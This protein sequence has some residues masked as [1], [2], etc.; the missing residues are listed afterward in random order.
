[1]SSSTLDFGIGLF[2][3][4]GKAFKKEEIIF[5]EYEPGN[6]FFFL[7]EGRI[8]VTKISADKEKTLD[9]LSPGEIFGEMAILEDAPRS[10]TMIALDDVK[11]LE[12]NK[13]NF[14]G[15]MQSKPELAIKLLRAFAK[16][17]YDQKR[18][19]MIL[20]LTEPDIKIMD[21]F[22]ML[23]ENR[24]LDIY[25]SMDIKFDITTED[26]ANWCGMD[27]SKCN[28]ILSHFQKQN[29]IVLS[30]NSITVTNINDFYRMVNSKRKSFKK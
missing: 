22:L 28:Q 14:N 24:G 19:L 20:T 23:A 6:S 27:K 11:V 4:F 17:I 13:A 3:K 9:I 18:R 16:R 8:K 21:V 26:V 7:L 15:L 2:G 30:Q 12:F 29:R 25:N 5:C 1:M 10:A